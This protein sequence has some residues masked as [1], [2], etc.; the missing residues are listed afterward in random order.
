MWGAS[1]GSTRYAAGGKGAFVS[2]VLNILK[3]KVFYVYIGGQGQNGAY[4]KAITK[5]SCNG[6]A[7]GGSPIDAKFV[8]GGS[9]G[10]STDIR[11]N[12]S[13]DSRILVAAGGGGACHIYNGGNAGALE[14]NDVKGYSL[15]SKGASQTNGYSKLYGQPGRAGT[16]RDFGSEGNGGGGAGYYGGFSS[17]NSGAKTNTPGAGGSSFISGFHNDRVSGFYFFQP[18]M[19]KGGEI[20]KNA[21]ETTQYNV[22]HVGDGFAII[23]KIGE[24]ITDNKSIISINFIRGFYI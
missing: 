14:S 5:E 16:Y 7:S 2:G 18:L 1:G 11:I 13:I 10:G 22:G 15:F 9:G 3:K 4:V 21:S 6:G 19:K 8:S 12:E 17:Q 20:M 23:T 24:L